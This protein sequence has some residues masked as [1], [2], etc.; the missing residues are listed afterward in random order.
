MKL[1]MANYLR[2]GMRKPRSLV[3]ECVPDGEQSIGTSESSLKKT[4]LLEKNR[5]I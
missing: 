3:D 4:I 2:N 5:Y 1:L